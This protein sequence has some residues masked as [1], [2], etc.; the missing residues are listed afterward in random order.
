MISQKRQL[1]GLLTSQACTMPRTSHISMPNTTHPTCRGLFL[2]HLLVVIL[3]F[4]H[5]FQALAGNWMT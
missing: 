4:I 2:R 1:S 5:S 3:L